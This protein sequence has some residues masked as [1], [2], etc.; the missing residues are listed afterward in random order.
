MSALD[1]SGHSTIHRI[2]GSSIENLRLKSQEAGLEPP[3]ISVLHAVTPAGAALE[4]RSA[5]PDATGLHRA[6]ATIASGT[7][8]AIRAAGFDVIFAPSRRLLNHCRLVHPEGVAGF[9]DLNLERLRQA[10]ADTNGN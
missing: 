2:G 9:T 8:A 1:L 7:V 6:A 4:L 5:Y 3:G 10:F